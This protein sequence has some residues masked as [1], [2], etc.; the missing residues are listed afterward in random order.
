MI[1]THLVCNRL[2]K[3]DWEDREYAHHLKKINDIK[4]RKSELNNTSSSSSST[5]F[6]HIYSNPKKAQKLQEQKYENEKEMHSIEQRISRIKTRGQTDS[7]NP[8]YIKNNNREAGKRKQRNEVEIENDRLGK[9]I[10]NVKGMYSF[11]QSIKE[12]E[13]HR[14]LLKLNERK[15]YTPRG[16]GHRKS[17]SLPEV[18]KGKTSKNKNTIKLLNAAVNQLERGDV[19]LMKTLIKLN[20]L[21]RI[22]TKRKY[23]QT[24]QTD[25]KKGLIKVMDKQFEPL[26]QALLTETDTL[27]VDK[28]YESLYDQ[29]DASIV[30]TE[31]F[32]S[33]NLEQKSSLL[34]A[35]HQKMD[36]E[37][38]TEISSKIEGDL[39]TFLL[40]F[41]QNDNLDNNSSDNQK[42]NK[43]VKSLDKL[44]SFITPAFLDIIKTDTRIQL[45]NLFEEYQ[46]VY[47]T[48]IASKMDANR[49][50][51]KAVKLIQV[52]LANT[53]LYMTEKLQKSLKTNK[54]DFL[55]QLV[56]FS[57]KDL[58]S[59]MDEYKQKY[60]TTLEDDIN[61][62]FSNEVFQLI[63]KIL[64]K[65]NSSSEDEY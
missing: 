23:E 38:K 10:I 50:V 26:I 58:R 19:V 35:F 17:R 30:I 54:S 48:D 34:L 3:E 65:N 56:T 31:C 41:L 1:S 20:Y 28:I 36:S 2:V 12:Y 32:I 8:S 27:D 63:I 43:D 46:K 39:R 5:K 24:Y 62:N 9:K 13:R 45:K 14:S 29:S 15:F 7:W 44:T 4:N 21:E 25:L 60:Q 37:L 51:V 33:R 22:E 55:R 52:Y 64:H 61:Q 40:A 59:V 53:I 11:E 16:M 6:P 57:S 42:L 49:P 18:R 47:K